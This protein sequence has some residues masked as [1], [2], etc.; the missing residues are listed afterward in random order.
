MAKVI[1][2][3]HRKTGFTR[4]ECSQYWSGERHTSVVKRIPGLKRWIQN[5]VVTAP[6]EPVCDGIGEMWFESDEA[7]DK[8]LKSAEMGAAVDD[9]KNFLDM[10]KTG[11]LIVTEKTVIA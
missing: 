4:E 7:M 3:L 8:A 6:G 11:L 1:F 9:A 10:E 2:V 5:H